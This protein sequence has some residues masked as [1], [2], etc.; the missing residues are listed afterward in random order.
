VGLCSKWWSRRW[1]SNPRPT[2]YEILLRASEGVHQNPVEGKLAPELSR[3]IPPGVSAST[4]LGVNGGVSEQILAPA[5]RCVEPL[6]LATVTVAHRDHR[7][8]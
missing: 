4:A 3:E 2:V 6:D 7:A 8:Y 1:D 5:G